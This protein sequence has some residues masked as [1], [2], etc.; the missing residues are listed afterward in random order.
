MALR[1]RLIRI[2][3]WLVFRNNQTRI[4]ELYNDIREIPNPISKTTTLIASI[5]RNIRTIPDT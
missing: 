3:G 5:V 2:S 4:G 1:I